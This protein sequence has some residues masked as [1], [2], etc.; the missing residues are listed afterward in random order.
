MEEKSETPGMFAPE[1]NANEVLSED[2]VIKAKMKLFSKIDKLDII[3]AGGTDMLGR[4][5]VVFSSC[6][7]P[8]PGVINMDALIEY[9]VLQLDKV[10]ESDYVIV[11]LH[12]GMSS[13]SRPKIAWVYKV[14]QTLT[15]SYKKNLK[16]LYIVHPTFWVKT[17]F[18]L[19]RPF[20]SPKFYSKI[21]YCGSLEELG[22]HISLMLLDIPQPVI[23]HNE[24]LHQ[25]SKE[26]LGPTSSPNGPNQQFGVALAFL[27]NEKE[28]I[29]LVLRKA[30]TRIAKEDGLTTEGLFRRSAGKVLVEHIKHCINYGMTVDWE[31][32][33]VHVAALLY[34]AFLREL[35]EPLLTFELF[36]EIIAYHKIPE[37][38][39]VPVLRTMIDALP[40]QN[41]AVLKFV[42]DTMELVVSHSQSNLMTPSN[43]T[44]VFA[45][46]LLWAKNR[47]ATLVTMN[48]AATFLMSL[49]THRAIFN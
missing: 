48:H 35:P 42:I 31:E 27:V 14:W 29:P 41:R 21:S 10:V 2:E 25:R 24:K 30:A 49:Y 11:Y 18:T 5:V 36:D 45:P 12:A 46:N 23:Q 17:L 9:M 22:C 1:A 4:P 26:M 39:R 33:D 47:A 7:L 19:T 20:I 8:G 13:D 16:Q 43:M 34:K 28:P 38:K 6:R 15:R 44:I 37:E 3:Q 40:S 32:M